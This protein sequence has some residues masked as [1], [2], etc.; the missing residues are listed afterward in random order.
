MFSSNN[1]PNTQQNSVDPAAAKPKRKLGWLALLTGV[2]MAVIGVIIFIRP[3]SVISLC[4]T[5]IAMQ[6]VIN[7]IKF[8]SAKEARTFKVYAKLVF[9]LILIILAILLLIQPPFAVTL[10]YYIVAAW[11]MFEGI[12][13]YMQVNTVRPV[14]NTL[15]FLIL[16]CNTL[17]FI[18]AVVLLFNSRFPEDS[19]AFITILMGASLILSGA[20]YF[21]FGLAGLNRTPRG[22][23]GPPADPQKR[24]PGN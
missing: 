9:S 10:F 20:I 13:N 15:F 21:M 11:L 6:G 18:S 1:A 19:K 2:I 23:F 7:L 3:D 4:G 12:N 14:N 5:V 22:N 16:G 17:L 8:L 24:L